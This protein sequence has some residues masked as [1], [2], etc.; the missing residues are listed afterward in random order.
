MTAH[1]STV[2]A[3]LK[4]VAPTLNIHSYMTIPGASDLYRFTASHG[5]PVRPMT[6]GDYAEI[7]SSTFDNNFTLV[8]SSLQPLGVI[9]H[10][11][12]ISGLLKAN[13]VSVPVTSSDLK[14][15]RLIA[16]N[17]FMDAE[18]NIWN[19]VGEGQSRRLLK[20]KPEDIQAII[21]ARMNRKTHTTVISSQYKGFSGYLPEKGDYIM[22]FSPAS[23]DYDFGYA[24]VA[25]NMVHVCGRKSGRNEVVHSAL[26]VECIDGNS[27][28]PP[29]VKMKASTDAVDY[30]TEGDFTEEQATRY[31][32]Y[33]RQLFAGTDFF[34]SIE[35]E[36]QDRRNLSQNN[37]PLTTMRPNL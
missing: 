30:P 5:I 2:L 6:F 18:D 24:V 25:N 7:V 11:Q 3:K 1:L 29:K 28:N 8:E 27:L 16:S 26:V 13:S 10:S 31:L 4:D 21:K 35:K 36:I 17:I 9:R 32:N 12:I 22:Y 23:D 15:Y 33:M 20:N 34:A 37:A 19:L 14:K